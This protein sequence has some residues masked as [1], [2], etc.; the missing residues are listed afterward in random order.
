MMKDCGFGNI[1]YMKRAGQGSISL[2]TESSG[3]YFSLFSLNLRREA[4]IH[5]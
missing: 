2:N 5:L 4:F 3:E 1:L